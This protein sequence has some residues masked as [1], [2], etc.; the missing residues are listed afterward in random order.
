MQHT[1][2]TMQTITEIDKIVIEV[3]VTFFSVFFFIF[4]AFIS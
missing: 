2:L 1:L 3:V 4:G